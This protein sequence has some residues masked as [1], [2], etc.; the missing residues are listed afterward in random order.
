MVNLDTIQDFRDQVNANSNYTL[1]AYRNKNGKNYWNIICACMDWIDVGVEYMNGFSFDRKKLGARGLEVFTYISAI[2][3]VWE[4]IQQLHRAIIDEKEVPFSGEKDVFINDVLHKDDNTYFKHVRAVFGA[5]PVNLSKDKNNDKWFASWPTSG[6]HEKYDVAIYLYNVDPS[7]D[8][9][10]F[11]FKFAELNKFFAKRY[12]HLFYLAKKLEEQ[13]Q[14]YKS[15]LILNGIRTTTNIEDQLDILED[16]LNNRL[17]NDYFENLVDRIK[18]IYKANVTNENN[19]G[20]I[21]DYRGKVNR[22]VEELTIKMQN[23]DYTDLKMD[24]IVYS[25]HPQEIHYELSKLFEC[26]YGYRKDEAYEY[27]IER[28]SKF[29]N[30][31]VQ[32]NKT[33]SADEIL[34]LLHVG[35]YNYWNSVEES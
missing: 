8:D 33:M 25:N 26:L 27:Y 12:N 30:S 19:R 2:D 14:D 17:S 28:V 34:L 24:H 9:I 16:E 10:L 32:I 29:L 21:E 6:I 18:R 23:L 20:I 4:S 22:V 13:Y 11:G 35:L 31:Y 7:K 1:Y 5:H 3:I 15:S